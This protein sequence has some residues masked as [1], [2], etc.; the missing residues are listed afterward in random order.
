[1]EER[2]CLSLGEGGLRAY[3]KFIEGGG[4]DANL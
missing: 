4:C 2:L 3:L 1:M